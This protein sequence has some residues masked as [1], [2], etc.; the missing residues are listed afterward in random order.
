MIYAFEREKKLYSVDEEE[1]Y[2]Y[3]K[4]I[5]R[6]SQENKDIPIRNAVS[7]FCKL[8]F[9]RID[10]ESEL[11]QFNNV[12]FQIFPYVD[13][14]YLVKWAKRYYDTC[15]KV[16]EDEILIKRGAVDPLDYDYDVF[17]AR[18]R[19]DFIFENKIPFHETI[20]KLA[21][22]NLENDTL[23]KIAAES[24]ATFRDALSLL[25][26]EH[27]PWYWKVGFVLGIPLML[28]GLWQ[29]L[30]KKESK[31]LL[32]AG[33][34][35]L[36]S[37]GILYYMKSKATQLGYRAESTEGQSKGERSVFSY[38]E[39]DRKQQ[40]PYSYSPFP[41]SALS[42]PGYPYSTGGYYVPKD[43]QPD[44]TFGDV[45]TT[46]PKSLDFSEYKPKTLEQSLE[47][48]NLNIPPL[49][50]MQEGREP[51]AGMV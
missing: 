33:L 21:D 26:S 9:S 24:E 35:A 27:V 28:Y 23:E 30:G 6:I 14:N 44:L 32:T 19:E 46:T 22:I 7:V 49:Y 50:T 12:L 1:Q 25:F 41:S 43:Y 36:L 31:G 40:M 48:P 13:P 11:I 37:I 38:F 29:A 4:R 51:G 15:R 18:Y 10:D 39:P 2:R 47:L 20:R 16:L 5:Y 8:A 45:R 17:R 3:L 34:G 42:V